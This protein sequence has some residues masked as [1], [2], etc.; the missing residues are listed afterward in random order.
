M[1]K[2]QPTNIK[3][4]K[5]VAVMHGECWLLPVDKL[6]KGKISEHNLFIIGHSE[7]GHNHV[8]ESKQPFQVMDETEKRDLYIRLFEP[9]KLVH[10]KSFDI[11]EAQVLAPGDYAV[12]HKT[13]YDPFREVVRQVFD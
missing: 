6:P 3:D 11:H 10:K 4:G 2:L 13:E 8:L 12:Y 7:S 9:A 5:R 1:A